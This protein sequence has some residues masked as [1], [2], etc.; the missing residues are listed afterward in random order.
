MCPSMSNNIFPRKQSYKSNLRKI[1]S[2]AQKQPDFAQM[3]RIKHVIMYNI[4]DDFSTG[5][6]EPAGDMRVSGKS[7]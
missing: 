3:A 4:T 2:F 6:H 7:G 5:K 1:S